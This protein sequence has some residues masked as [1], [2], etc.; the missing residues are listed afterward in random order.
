[1]RV[2]RRLLVSG[3][4]SLY[5]SRRYEVL[6]KRAVANLLPRRVVRLVDRARVWVMRRRNAALPTRDV[7]TRIYEANRWGGEGGDFFSGSGSTKDFAEQYAAAVKTLI[8]EEGIARVVDLGCGDF[9]V[10]EKLQ[11]EGVEYV[12][13]DIVERLVEH[14]REQ[15]AT[16]QTSFRCLDITKDELPDGD[17]CLIRQVLQHLSNDQIAAILRQVRKYRYVLVTEHYPAPSVAVVPNRDKVH[18]GD[19]RTYDH[20][21]VFLDR[22]PF[23]VKGL[24]KVL[25]LPARDWLVTEGE[26]IT[27]YLFENS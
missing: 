7:F 2:E 19:T 27:T 15:Y 6:M 23:G 11:M 25:E 12:G 13:V 22:P 21:A 17:L 26:T 9:T 20:S 16:P 14:L 18:G 10:G 1:M 3:A 8:R 5:L 4:P 24:R